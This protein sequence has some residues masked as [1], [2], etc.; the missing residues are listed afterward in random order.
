MATPLQLKSIS[1][2][3]QVGGTSDFQLTELTPDV[4]KQLVPDEVQWVQPPGDPYKYQFLP[5]GQQVAT[6]NTKT[7]KQDLMDV[8]TLQKA[9]PAFFNQGIVSQALQ[10]SIAALKEGTGQERPATADDLSVI[11]GGNIT[12]A[13]TGPQAITPA[14]MGGLNPV[15]QE[16]APVNPRRESFLE[17]FGR[18]MGLPGVQRSLGALAQAIGGKDS[19]GGRLGQ[20]AIEGAEAEAT[21]ILFG[22]IA[23]GDSIADALADPRVKGALSP[24][25]VTAATASK[26][27][28][29]KVEQSGKATDAQV[30]L[31]DAQISKYQAD[32]EQGWEKLILEGQSISNRFE[33]DMKQQEIAGRAQASLENYHNAYA[34]YLGTRGSGDTEARMQALLTRT[35]A[36]RNV[37]TSIIEMDEHIE[38][39][40][41]Q[42][43][44]INLLADG[45]ALTPEQI[46]LQ[47]D[48]KDRISE[49][50]KDVTNART[51]YREINT[52][53]SK[54]NTTPQGEPTPEPEGEGEE[55]PSAPLS[56]E[57]A[58][59]Q[60]T[61]VLTT[62]FNKALETPG[63]SSLIASIRAKVAQAATVDKSA[64]E[65]TMSAGEWSFKKRSKASFSAVEYDA[66]LF[67]VARDMA[68]EGAAQA[69]INKVE[70]RLRKLVPFNQ[71]DTFLPDA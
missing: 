63:D 62:D 31:S 43:D 50:R 32:I 61:S 55:T 6:H 22:R 4:K 5:G 48:L 68:G 26:R 28:D 14:P 39:L 33:V 37:M 2:L 30:K 60:V 42:Y 64:K 44:T 20:V 51:Q 52:L 13:R 12:P 15:M 34:A 27:E 10:S 45:D 71:L 58:K 41:K 69:D 66:L 16:T 67:Q 25:A 19:I 57:E 35:N 59:K 56:K 9:N 36:G 8:A 17:G 40:Q 21:R 1:R 49:A 3:L 70:A 24:Q 7:G 47:K 65:T 53:D 46:E 11:T 29:T 38:N 23:Q 54:G 18:A